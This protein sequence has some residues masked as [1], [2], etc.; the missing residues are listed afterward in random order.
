MLSDLTNQQYTVQVRQR[1]QLTIPQKIRE[2][3]AIEDGDTLNIVMVG[4]AILL[5]PK[6][7]RTQGLAERIADLLDEEG[8]SLADLLKGLPRIRTEVYQERYGDLEA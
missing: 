5:T 3:L 2:S 6:V 4:E 8:I 1:G 7:T